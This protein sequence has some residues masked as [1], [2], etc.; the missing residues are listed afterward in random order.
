[1]RFTTK[2][3]RVVFPSR[4]R[5][6]TTNE[7]RVHHFS[8]VFPRLFTE[9]A[10]PLERLARIAAYMGRARNK[11]VWL[12]WQIADDAAK[13]F[14]N[15]LADILLRAAI[16]YQTTLHIK[17]W[18]RHYFTACSDRDRKSAIVTESRVGKA[19]RIVDHVQPIT[20]NHSSALIWVGPETSLSG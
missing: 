19:N 6:A 17:R 18:V 14:P 20:G 16:T 7:K 13:L 5:P 1:M 10:D 15:T 12:N 4:A 3:L 2:S 9:I 8:Y 11:S